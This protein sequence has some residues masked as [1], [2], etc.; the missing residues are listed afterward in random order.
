[1]KKF[2]AMMLALAMVLALAACG[3]SA[4]P[5]ATEAPAAE[6]PAAEA[7]AAEAPAAA[8]GKT[9]GVAMPT[10]SSERWIND[11]ANMKKQLEALGYK[12]E[13]QYAEDDVQMQV[14]QIENM[15]ASGVDCL[16]I[17]SIDSVALTGVEAQAK[18]AGIP[19][20]AYDRL[21]M[22]TDAVSYY[23]S[24]DNEGVG[25]AIGEYIEQAK[26][27]ANTTETYTIEFF[28]GSPDD[29]NAVLLHRGV[30]KVL[31]PYLDSGV[32][33]CK[34]GR[35]SFEDTCILRWSQETAQKNCED[36]LAGFYA[37]EDLDI[38][39]TAFDGF[40]YGCRSALE[41]AGYT[42]GTN[43]PLITGQDA[44][45]MATKNII[46][47]HQT[48]SIYKDTRLLAEKC[49]TMVNAVLTGS[50]PEINDT[51]TYNNNV[52]VVPSYLCTPV[53]VDQSNYEE[54]IVGGGYYTA[55]QLAG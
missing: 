34:S 8:E 5:A 6:A 26:D 17:A 32:L 27:L 4:A 7:P 52:I 30:M 46:S 47:G 29:N 10:Q 22:D 48:M 37:D 43:W 13:L 14:S 54:I 38:C 44:E 16:V 33:V 19:I 2:L 39:C 42:V 55:E 11:G 51:E 24:F 18:E 23:A 9:V 28:M 36:Y 49:V 25:R 35:T 3:G 50:E 20:I 53:A 45:L 1:M 31:Q 41:A 12:V 15:I 21:L 40:A